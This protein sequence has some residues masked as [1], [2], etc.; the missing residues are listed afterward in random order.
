MDFTV[1]YLGAIAG[2]VIAIIGII[3][4]IAPVYSLILGAFIGGLLGGATI[5]QSVA[6]IIS[7]SAG[8][9]PA[10]IRILTAGVLVGVLVKTRATT[11]IGMTIINLF[12]EK[13]KLGVFFSLIV[14]SAILTAM[15]VFIDITVITLAPIALEIA[16]RLKLSRSAILLALVSGGKAGNVVSPNPNTI[17]GAEAFNIDLL[18]LMGANLV[19]SILVIISSVFIVSLVNRRFTNIVNEIDKENINNEYMPS[20]FQA[21]IAPLVTILLLALRPLVNITIDPLIA[22][23]VG[24]LVGCVAMGKIK[25]FSEYIQ[26]GLSRM[27]GVALLLLGTGAIAG[28]IKGSD[29]TEACIRS[30]QNL[31]IS[32]EFLAPM[33]GILMS[34]ATAS[35]TAGTAV[36]SNTFGPILLEAGIDPVS[37]AATIHT[38]ATVL[39]HV[40]HGSFFHATA[41]AVNMNFRD[42]LRLIPYESLVGLMLVTASWIIHFM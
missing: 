1:S 6:L 2:L 24:G 42:R 18:T 31:G 21:L 11:K 15:G 29:L 25:E 8:I 39:D 16:N 33:A 40:P 26:F 12:G 14:A 41:G 35:T 27:S 10:V 7:G 38:G 37:A 20:L 22:L 9:I 36:A 3:Y 23:P 17:S 13:N 19:P 32:I 4:K 34:F 30:L 5:S 28:I